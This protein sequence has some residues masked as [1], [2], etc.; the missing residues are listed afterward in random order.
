MKRK[1]SIAILLP[2][3]SARPIGGAKALYRYADELAAAGNHVALVHPRESLL[4]TVRDRLDRDTSLFG[5][6]PRP[7]VSAEPPS[8]S[9]GDPHRWYSVRPDVEDLLVPDL[10]EANIRGAFDVTVVTN[11]LMLPI[12]QSYSER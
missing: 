5:P 11:F 6:P 2:E 12:V 1:L 9:G 8:R 4:T 7:A 3:V 10:E